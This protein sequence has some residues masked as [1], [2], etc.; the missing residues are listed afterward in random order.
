MIRAILLRVWE[1][2]RLQ[3]ATETSEITQGHWWYH[4]VG[5]VISNYS[6]IVSMPSE[7][8]HC[9]LGVRKSIQPVKIEWWV[10]TQF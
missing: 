9:W 6:S 4:S 5:H 3:T 2:E 1:L 8:W 7:L 10:I